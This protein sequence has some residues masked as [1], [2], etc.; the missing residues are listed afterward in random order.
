M[1]EP[2]RV[3]RCRGCAS[4]LTAGRACTC[5]TKTVHIITTLGPTD[6]PGLVVPAQLSASHG[7]GSARFTYGGTDL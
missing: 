6:G 4:L 5:D 2:A 3:R 1:T 7:P